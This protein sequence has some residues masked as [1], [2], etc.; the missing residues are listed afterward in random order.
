MDITGYEQKKRDAILA[1]ET[2]FVTPERNR[3]IVEW[4][5]A[6]NCYFGSRIRTKAAE[7][8]TVKEPLGLTSLDDLT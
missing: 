5:A 6:G 4:L 8:F 3:W 2:Q 1:Y 7:P